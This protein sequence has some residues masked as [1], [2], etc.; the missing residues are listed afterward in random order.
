MLLYLLSSFRVYFYGYGVSDLK[1]RILYS[2]EYYAIIGLDIINFTIIYITKVWLLST[3]TRI[4]DCLIEDNIFS[5]YSQD[6]CLE[7]E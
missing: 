4:K 3:A 6:L 2:M 7:L 5:F 1:V